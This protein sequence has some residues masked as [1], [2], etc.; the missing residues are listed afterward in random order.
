MDQSEIAPVLGDG[1][2]KRGKFLRSRARV[3]LAVV[4]AVVVL[5]ATAAVADV[6]VSGS[7]GGSALGVQISSGTSVPGVTFPGAQGTGSASA[8]VCQFTGLTETPAGVIVVGSG[9]PGY[10]YLIACPGW[11]VGFGGSGL[12]WVPA[13]PAA[14][15]P[16]TTDPSTVAAQAAGEISLPVPEIQFSPAPFTVVNLSTWLWINPSMWHSYSASASVAG[17]TASATAV[18]VSVRWT[19]G[20]GSSVVCTGPGTPYRSTVASSAQSTTCSHV[21]RTTSAGQPSADGNPNDGAFTVTATITWE[22]SWSSSIAGTGGA[23]PSLQTESSAR[24]RVEQVQSV[25]TVH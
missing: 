25:D 16:V 24:L 18:P 5:G 1:A 9:G 3:V 12:L 10:L 4:V 7:D 13:I 14:A 23:L 2:R 20:D 11:S 8:P 6:S 21:Y 22:V 19:T 17:V 15:A